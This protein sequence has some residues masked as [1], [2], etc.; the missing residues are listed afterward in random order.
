MAHTEYL[1]TGAGEWSYP[2][3][4][5]LVVLD[6]SLFWGFLLTNFIPR[7]SFRKR[8]LQR[9]SGLLN[10]APYGARTNLD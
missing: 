3:V 7:Y 6:A 9:C 1:T 2:L 8:S 10:A 5:L 4:F